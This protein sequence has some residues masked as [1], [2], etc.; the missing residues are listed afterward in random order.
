MF[1][2]ALFLSYNF[3]GTVFFDAFEQKTDFGTKGRV[4]LEN[5][6]VS[7]RATLHRNETG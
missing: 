6:S 1:R 2:N 5:V 7:D 3:T 4:K